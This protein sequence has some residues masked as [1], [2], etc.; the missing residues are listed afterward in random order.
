[1]IFFRGQRIM[2]ERAKKGVYTYNYTF[3][4]TTYYVLFIPVFVSKQILKYDVR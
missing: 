1:M 4:V 3:S 2:R